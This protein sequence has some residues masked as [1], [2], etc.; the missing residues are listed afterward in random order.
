MGKVSA[1]VGLHTRVFSDG[2]T[3]ALKIH[4]MLTGKDS[5]AA[6]MFSELASKALESMNRQSDEAL[7]CK[8]LLTRACN[9]DLASIEHCFAMMMADIQAFRRANTHIPRIAHVGPLGF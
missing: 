4:S 8:N 2:E 7:L 3:R 5:D 6:G 9:M 1:S